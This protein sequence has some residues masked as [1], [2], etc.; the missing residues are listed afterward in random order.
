MD[1][2]Q[3]N[4]FVDNTEQSY[5]QRDLLDSMARLLPGNQWSTI[6]TVFSYMAI[7]ESEISI[8]QCQYPDKSDTLHDAFITCGDVSS[9]MYQVSEKVFRSHTREILCRVAQGQNIRPATKAEILLALHAT[10]LRTPLI[11]DAVALYVRLFEEIMGVQVES[12]YNPVPSYIGA[13]DEIEQQLRNTLRK[14][15]RGQIRF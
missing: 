5:P 4:L 13:D 2:R 10:S 9:E 11:P 15:N 8:A 1:I 7:V 3:L 6:N 14:P 12:D